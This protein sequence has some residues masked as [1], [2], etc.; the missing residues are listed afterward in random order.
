MKICKTHP[1]KE[2][3][4]RDGQHGPFYSHV[5][6]GDKENGYT[7][8]NANMEQIAS[9]VLPEETIADI[10]KEPG[11]TTNHSDSFFTCNAMNNTVNLIVGG[12]V[13]I[14]DLEDCYNR[15]LKIL[16]K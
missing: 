9:E 15:I 10:A 14:K 2:F 6:S 8:H 3:K 11:D 1:G 7:Y 5:I 4:L 13:E 16:E 12:K